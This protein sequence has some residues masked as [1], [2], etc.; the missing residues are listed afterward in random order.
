MPQSNPVYFDSIILRED[1]LAALRKDA[2]ATE[3]AF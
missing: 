2:N 1:H 3:E